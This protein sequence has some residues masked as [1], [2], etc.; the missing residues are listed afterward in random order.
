[1]DPRCC[2]QL[3]MIYIVFMGL[4]IVNP[5]VPNW[6]QPLVFPLVCTFGLVKSPEIGSTSDGSTKTRMVCNSKGFGRLLFEK[7][8]RWSYRNFK[9]Q[10]SLALEQTSVLAFPFPFDKYQSDTSRFG[11]TGWPSWQGSCDDSDETVT[12]ILR[13][14]MFS[15][16]ALSAETVPS[17]WMAGL[18][19]LDG[20]KK[21]SYTETSW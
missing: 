9:V 15:S 16:W 13:T 20:Q 14:E 2:V 1:M 11:Q 19:A 17:N 10:P 4:I 3:R 5:M 18:L 12:R 6:F 7:K 21:H 8:K